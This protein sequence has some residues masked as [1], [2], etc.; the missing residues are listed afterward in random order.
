MKLGLILKFE[1][2]TNKKYTT[3]KIKMH[4]LSYVK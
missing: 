4:R 1:Q 2:G 3:G